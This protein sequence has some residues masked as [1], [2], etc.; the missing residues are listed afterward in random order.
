MNVSFSKNAFASNGSR[1]EKKSIDWLLSYSCKLN[2]KSEKGQDGA[3]FAYDA[4]TAGIDN[5]RGS[6]GLLFIDIDKLDKKTAEVIFGGFQYMANYLPSLYAVQYSSSHFLHETKS[7]LHFYVTTRAGL[8][9]KEYAYLANLAYAAILQIIKMWFKI[10]LRDIPGA[11]DD[12]NSKMSQKFFVHY[13]P[14]RKG[15]FWS[16]EM[17]FDEN[18]L[19]KK[20]IDGLHKQYGEF[21]RLS[22]QTKEP[23]VE[24]ITNIKAVEANKSKLLIDRNFVVAGYRGNDVRW[25]I[26]NI[27]IHVFGDA[28]KA[29]EWCD[30]YFYRIDKGKEVSIFNCKR[31]T[32]ISPAIQ[33]WLIECGYLVVD[34]PDPLYDGLYLG[35]GEYMT[36]RKK[37]ILKF[38]NNNSRCEIVSGTGTGKTTLI[39]EI[40]KEL[41]AVVI[42]PFNVTNNL[43]NMVCVS[44]E[45]ITPVPENAPCTMVWDQAIMHWMEIKDRALIVDEAHCLFTDR[46]YRDCA[47]KLMLR[48]KDRKGKLVLFTATPAGETEE[49]G[50]TM[51]K[52]DSRR[53][54]IPVNVIK[55]NHIDVAQYRAILKALREGWY[56]RV[57][58][59]D[60]RNARKIYEKLYIEGELINE[61]AYIRADTKKTE[62][63][64]SLR[65]TEMLSKK[66]TICTCVAF[67][68]LNFKNKNER[69][70]VVTSW[71]PG[72]TIANELI[73]EV[74]RVRESN[75]QMMVFW[76]GK[77]KEDTLNER[78]NIAEKLNDFEIEKDVSA[79]LLEY[80][81][82][83]L[84]MGYQQA[85]MTIQDYINVHSL[86]VPQELSEV[87]YL[88]VSEIDRQT[89][90]PIGS[91]IKLEKKRKENKEFISDIDNVLNVE[92]E[93]VE[94]N[95][96]KIQWQ[97]QARRLIQGS[98]YEGVDIG[99]FKEVL[100]NKK[101][102]VMFETVLNEIGRIIM[103]SLLTDKQWR[104]YE[105]NIDKV[106]ELVGNDAIKQ[107][108]IAS[109]FKRDK[110][111]RNKYSSRVVM[112]SFDHIDLEDVFNAY[113]GDVKGEYGAFKASHQKKVRIA[114]LMPES[115]R[116]KY[117]LHIGDEF[118]SCNSIAERCGVSVQSVSK[119]VKKG[120][121]G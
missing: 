109:R 121:L 8:D 89:D 80:D 110:E 36:H 54:P 30:R 74:G 58:L 114:A 4:D 12:H 90:K 61:V 22:K 94:A 82:K 46:S 64:I 103:I 16:E 116:S 62:D 100:N 111:I 59:F 56:D 57:V 120:W 99:L 88:V 69:I 47:V 34:D 55:V 92:Y 104:N 105:S 63:F 67:N 52:V 77:V 35:V 112:T 98:N 107:K 10:D 117:Q 6:G 106:K 79:G 3:V 66:L 113:L 19:S 51:L 42:V 26:S 83:L 20:D 72:E 70:L 49:L 53:N 101:K 44:S 93:P 38:I 29:K 33:N 43:Y 78:I 31:P 48:L 11:I 5:A 84:D 1:L 81:H 25:R 32:A 39:N 28:N 85:M 75:V 118:E 73:Q 60:D 15:M 115:K 45:T 76:D 86:K 23:K 91:V 71:I 17:L 41:N 7:G 14:Y 18:F 37:E 65:E 24:T 95:Q 13:S 96:Y 102:D 9:R 40:A 97:K 68:G 50:C 21:L 2:P 108:Q 27:A 119:W 87:G